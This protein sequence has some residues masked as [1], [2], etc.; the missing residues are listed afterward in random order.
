MRQ[1]EEAN[2]SKELEL[3]DGLSNV[4]LQAQRRAGAELDFLRTRVGEM[5]SDKGAAGQVTKDL[6]ELRVV[7]GKI[8]PGSN[9]VARSSVCGRCPSPAASLGG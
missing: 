5:L 9:Q 7:L 3:A 4:G 8:S 1:L 2:G 6:V